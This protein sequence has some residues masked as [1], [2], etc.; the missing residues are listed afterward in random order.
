VGA[1]K[2]AGLRRFRGEAWLRGSLEL[3][4]QVQAFDA[5]PISDGFRRGWAEPL[6]READDVLGGRGA[7]VVIGLGLTCK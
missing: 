4:Q 2:T 6:Q 3:M 5:A 1:W 7:A